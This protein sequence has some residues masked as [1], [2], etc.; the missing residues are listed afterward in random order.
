M[1]HELLHDFAGVGARLIHLVDGDDDGDVGGA[2][3]VDGLDGLR[4]D[5]VIGRDDQDDDVGDGGAAGPHRGEGGV[6]GGIDEGDLLAVYFLLVGADILRDATGLGIDDARGADSVDEGGLAMVD[7]AHDGDNRRAL[8]QARG[9]IDDLEFLETGLVHHRLFLEVVVVFQADSADGLV[10][11]QLV[12][13]DGLATK[14]EELDDGGARD[15]DGF[16]ELGHGD[17]LGIDED[18]TVDFGVVLLLPLFRL[19]VAHPLGAGGGV[20]LLGRI[21]VVLFLHDVSPF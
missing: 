15:V 10:I 20:I 21:I 3:V 18:A 2:G 7:V 19:E 13:G 14:E 1:G 16:G 9:V 11:E 5:A 12:D 17:G 6:P 8:L 4:H